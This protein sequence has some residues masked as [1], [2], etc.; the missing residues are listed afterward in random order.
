MEV[1]YEEPIN[2]NIIYFIAVIS[3]NTV[4]YSRR[5]YVSWGGA[6]CF[7]GASLLVALLAVVN[8]V[9]A[10]DA[11]HAE[12]DEKAA[13]KA[14]FRALEKRKS[15][16]IDKVADEATL[17]LAEQIVEFK[18]PVMARDRAASA[19]VDK[20]RREALSKARSDEERAVGLAKRKSAYDTAN[21]LSL[22]AAQP[23]FDGSKYSVFGFVFTSF[24]ERLSEAARVAKSTF[25]EKAWEKAEKIIEEAGR[26]SEY[27]AA[28]SEYDAVHAD[29]YAKIYGKPY[30]KPSYEE[31]IAAKDE[32]EDELAEAEAAEDELSEA[33]V[34]YE[35]SAAIADF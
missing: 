6:P 21:T 15:E 3:S 18:K 10:D 31:L 28:K 2:K 23:I 1:S 25:V 22:Q 19:K 5:L 34:A 20:T 9:S 7:L 27:V 30:V 11:T 4:W 24:S 13:N 8:G 26:K 35:A 29:L 17:A 33:E 16:L 32:E 12:P 14:A